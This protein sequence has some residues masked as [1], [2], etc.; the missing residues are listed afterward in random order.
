MRTNPPRYPRTFHW[1][2]SPEVHADDS[3]HGNP[4]V[5]VGQEVVITEKLDG[6]NTCLWNGDV[7]ARSTSTPSN[8]G[9]FAMVKKH[10]AWKMFVICFENFIP[11]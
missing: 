11:G 9:W 2:E 10:H 8:D 6:G 5:F 7:Y 1:H 3:Y 4:N